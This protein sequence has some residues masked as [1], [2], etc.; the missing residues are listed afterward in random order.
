MNEDRLVFSQAPRTSS[1]PTLMSIAIISVE[2]PQH[3]WNRLPGDTGIEQGIF[4]IVPG[5]TVCFSSG[6]LQYNDA[7]VTH[8]CVDG[9]I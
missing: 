1:I 8:Q 7:L 2:Q 9:T 3:A 5:N 6:N 4:S